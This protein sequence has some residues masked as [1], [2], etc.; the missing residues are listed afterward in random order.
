MPDPS[1]PSLPIG[2]GSR[3]ATTADVHAIHRL[4]A[5]CEHELYGRAPTSADRIAADLG[6]S[7]PDLTCDAVL[8]H[9]SGGEPAGWGRVGGRR[10]TVDVHPAHHGRGLGRALL[11]WAEGRARR[12]GSDQLAQTA[13]DRDHAAVALLRSSGYSWL[14][15]VSGQV[16]TD[17]GEAAGRRLSP[18]PDPPW[19]CSAEPR[20][21]RCP[22]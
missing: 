19:S 18:R 10:S 3:S 2:Y 22:A 16:P 21:P 20:R 17:R 15:S 12:M 1:P 9:D 14:P 8:I 13:A 11:S 4:V 5:A 6:P 7:D